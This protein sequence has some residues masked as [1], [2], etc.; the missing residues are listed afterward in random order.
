[1]L[2]ILLKPEMN[3]ERVM[4]VPEKEEFI[5]NLGNSFE[6]ESRIGVAYDLYRVNSSIARRFAPSLIRR[7]NGMTI[8]EYVE[9]NNLRKSLQKN[10]PKNEVVKKK[11]KI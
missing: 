3:S 2:H 9:K 11:M 8:V 4:N 7:L 5:S 6:K 1:M 10:M